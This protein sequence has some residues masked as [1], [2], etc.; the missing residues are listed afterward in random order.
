M[1]VCTYVHERD[2]KHRKRHKGV[3]AQYRLEC[4]KVCAYTSSCMCMCACVHICACV[5]MKEMI[6]LHTHSVWH[7]DLLTQIHHTYLPRHTHTHTHI[8]THSVGPS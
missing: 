3:D 6:K 8:H 4:E 1:Y 7:H 5:C 2:Y